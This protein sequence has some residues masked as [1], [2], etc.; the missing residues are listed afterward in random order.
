MLGAAERCSLRP[1]IED[2]PLDIQLFISIIFLRA[3]GVDFSVTGYKMIRKEVRGGVRFAT[4]AD[5]DRSFLGINVSLSEFITVGWTKRQYCKQN[6]LAPTD[7]ETARKDCP[8][9]WTALC[10]IP[11]G[12]IL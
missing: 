8:F 12:N 11:S 5:F 9:Q 7:R 10:K 4:V 3:G 6:F 2:R 1:Q